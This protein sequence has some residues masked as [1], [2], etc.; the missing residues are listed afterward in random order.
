MILQSETQLLNNTQI[1]TDD[2]NL[3]ET[4][5]ANAL[6]EPI[7]KKM[8]FCLIHLMKIQVL[9]R[10]SNENIDR[11]NHHLHQ[12]PSTG[13]LNDLVQSELV[14]CETILK[15]ESSLCLLFFLHKY[16]LF[17]LPVLDLKVC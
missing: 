6:K 3:Q 9:Y 11:I 13:R 7:Q 12:L 4:N 15:T 14:F 17:L 2:L 1:F 16:T 8:N 5:D 10:I